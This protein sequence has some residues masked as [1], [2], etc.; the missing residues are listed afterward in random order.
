[1]RNII[2]FTFL[3]VT[4]IA[5]ISPFIKPDYVQR[6]PASFG[7]VQYGSVHYGSIHYGST[8]YGNHTNDVILKIYDD[9]PDPA[10]NLIGNRDDGTI[11]THEDSEV[12]VEEKRKRRFRA[13]VDGLKE[14]RELRQ[15]DK[16]SWKQA[17]EDGEE[18][19]RDTRK[20][21]REA[22]QER[23]QERRKARQGKDVS[24]Q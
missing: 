13:W 22:R 1:M 16:E 2:L 14:S 5:L 6:Y 8:P 12:K 10:E 3:C 4:A 9:A 11:N 23:R 7:E 21:L 17:K 19:W 15:V 20:E 24:E 18:S